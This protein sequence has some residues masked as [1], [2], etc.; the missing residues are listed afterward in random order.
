[1]MDD[2]QTS[3][4]ALQALADMGCELSIDDFGTGYTSLSYLKRLPVHEIKVDKSFVMRMESDADDAKIVHSAI[5]LA[6]NLGLSVIAEGVETATTW[7][8]LAAMRCDEAQGY[9]IA[10]PM[11]ADEFVGWVRRWRAPAGAPAAQDEARAV[12]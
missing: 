12:I 2:P 9:V 6:H 10:E 8:M 11:P 7:K 5:E 1:M 4:R 3:L